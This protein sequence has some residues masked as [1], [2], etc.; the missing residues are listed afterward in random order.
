MIGPFAAFRPHAVAGPPANLAGIDV[1]KVENAR[2]GVIDHFLD[3]T[4]QSVKCRDGWVYDAA[5]FGHGSHVADMPE[6]QWRFAEHEHEAA[7]LLQGNVSGTRNQVCGIA[8]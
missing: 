2:Q 3:R 8:G 5:D 6:M 7:P 1:E 4:G